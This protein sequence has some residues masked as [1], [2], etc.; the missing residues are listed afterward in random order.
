ML[1]F[2]LFSITEHSF[3]VKPLL[4]GV[5]ESCQETTRVFLRV[6]VYFA[7]GFVHIAMKERLSEQ[8]GASFSSTSELVDASDMYR[9]L[10]GWR[11][12]RE[13]DRLLPWINWGCFGVLGATR[14]SAQ[15]HFSMALSLLVG[16]TAMLPLLPFSLAM[17][18]RRG[19]RAGW[20]PQ[21]SGRGPA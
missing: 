20:A 17:G 4:C 3:S 18:A 11:A 16:R 9:T 15:C 7:P 1:S 2:P 14:R 13:D 8:R 10:P 5:A 21:I 6:D 19:E 12:E